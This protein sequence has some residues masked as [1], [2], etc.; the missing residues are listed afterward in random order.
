VLPKVMGNWTGAIHS[1]QPFEMEFPLLGS[2]RKFR[3]F[4]TRVNPF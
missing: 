2:D 4:L 3:V 1:G